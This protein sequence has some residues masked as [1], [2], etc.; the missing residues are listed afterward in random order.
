MVQRMLIDGTHPEETR[1]VVVNGTRLEDF[2]AEAASRQQIKGN[3]YLAKVTRVEPSLQAAFVEYGGNRHGF[4]AFGEIH[5][6]YYRIPVAD[7]EDL[8]EDEPEEDV[9]EDA[10]GNDGTPEEGASDLLE[11]ADAPLVQLRRPRTKRAYKI[12]EVIKRH[13]VLLVQAV[14][15][16]RGGKGAAMTTYISL[17]GRYCV[18]MPNSIRGGGVSRKIVNVADRKR[19]KTLMSDLVL[20]EGMGVI[21]RT[22]GADRSKPEIKRDFTY[23]VKLWEQIRQLTLESTA[24]AL[25]HEEANL[26]KRS[27]RDLYTKEMEEILVAGAEAHRIAKDFIK[28]L[29]PSHARKVQFYADE[30]EVPLFQRYQVEDQ[31]AAIHVPH[32]RLPSGGSL[33]IH[34]TEALVAIDVN[35]GKAIR[36]RHIEETAFKTNL[37][38]ADEAARQLRLRDLAG[39]IVIDFIDMEESKN[40]LAVERRL[41]EALKTDRARIQIGHISSF[42]LLE[43]SRQRMRPSLL[44]ATTHICAHCDGTGYVQSVEASALAALRGLEKEARRGAAEVTIAMNSA[45]ALYILNR[46]RGN[47][48]ELEKANGVTI[49]VESEDSL[50]PG[51]FNITR[52]VTGGSQKT[53]QEAPERAA[54]RE[55]PREQNGARPERDMRRTRPSATDAP[56]KPAE[57]KGRAAPAVTEEDDKTERPD[58]EAPRK[59]RRRRGGRRRSKQENRLDPATAMI[60][61]EEPDSGFAPLPETDDRDEAEDAPVADTPQEKGADGPEDQQQPTPARRRSRRARKPRATAEDAAANP[62][63]EPVSA[64]VA[65]APEAAAPQGEEADKAVEVAVSPRKRVRGRSRPR[66]PEAAADNAAPVTPPPAPEKEVPATPPLAAHS[67]AP[68]PVPAVADAAPAAESRPKKQGWWNRSAT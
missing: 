53:G 15:E 62:L 49:V 26:I 55:A 63:A 11:D 58:G 19:L 33:V 24:P 68:T 42:G 8:L 3:I 2:D 1:V 65:D 64:I 10:A 18:L 38:A 39:L 16:E 37:E 51:V 46:K 17:A 56:R 50:R 27:L 4:L 44:E 54:P 13:Q 60:A 67:P 20:P 9:R 22:A 41:K 59:R 47:L 52:T 5:P 25:V 30:E 29:I 14:K 23:L 6:D 36:E 32:V 34:Q 45:V 21:L 31:L 43:M 57:D 66:S 12:Q 7:R 28:A 48:V 61:G 40:N 35:S